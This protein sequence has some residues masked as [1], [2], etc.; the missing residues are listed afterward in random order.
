LKVLLGETLKS[1]T[2]CSDIF[3]DAKVSN[4]VKE[5]ISIIELMFVQQAKT[6]KFIF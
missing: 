2:T 6:V 3:L 5:I 1:L 4:L